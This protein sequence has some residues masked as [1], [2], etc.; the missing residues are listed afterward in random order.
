MLKKGGEIVLRSPS[1][2]KQAE[3]YL[4]GVW[5]ADIASFM[6][7]GGQSNPG[8]FHCIGFDE[9]TI[10]RYLHRVGLQVFK[11]EEP[12]IPQDKGYRNI[13]FTVWATK[14]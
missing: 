6:I 14:K 1:L 5:D 2:R 11:Y 3:M 9:T 12:D 10:R 4:R 7:F 8:D 13:N